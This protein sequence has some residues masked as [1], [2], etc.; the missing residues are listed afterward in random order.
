MVEKLRDRFR[1]SPDKAKILDSAIETPGAADS[2]VRLLHQE[3]A[4]DPRFR[5]Q[6]RELLLQ[7]SPVLA[8]DAVS[9]VFTGRAE[10]VVQ[11]RDVHG[12]LNIS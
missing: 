10:K 2:L 3:F 11:L 7:V 9:N 4:G 12:D 8:A 1:K 5:D 6:I